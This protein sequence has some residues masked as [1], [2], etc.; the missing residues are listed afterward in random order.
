MHE[1]LSLLE[2]LAVLAVL[3]AVAALGYANYSPTY[4]LNAGVAELRSL[5][6]AAR[7]E[8]IRR[9]TLATLRL[10]QG[11]LQLEV[12]GRVLRRFS[13]GGFGLTL[14]A[15]SEGQLNALGRPQEETL[16]AFTLSLGSR[17][18]SLCLEPGGLL[19]EVAG[20]GC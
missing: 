14:R 6:Q 1:G 16:L 5:L 15:P 10:D 9:G 19:R 13:P 4:R 3:G 17:K 12:K 20:D 2:L 7:T 11:A 8:A 18:R